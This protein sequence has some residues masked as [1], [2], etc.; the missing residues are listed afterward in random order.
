MGGRSISVRGAINLLAKR[1]KTGREIYVN[2][3]NEPLL[4]FI[5]IS[6]NFTNKI[7]T[8]ELGELEPRGE[9]NGNSEIVEC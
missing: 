7:G 2:F 3:Y 8:G 6:V 1:D 5:V 4:S 9:G